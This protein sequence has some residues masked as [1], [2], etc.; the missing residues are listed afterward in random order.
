VRSFPFH[1]FLI[2]SATVTDGFFLP[3]SSLPLSSTLTARKGSSPS[4]LASTPSRAGSP[5]SSPFPVPFILLVVLLLLSIYFPILSSALTF[6][7]HSHSLRPVKVEGITD[8]DC[9]DILNAGHLTLRDKIPEV[10]QRVARRHEYP[11][12]DVSATPEEGVEG[13]EEGV[14]RL[15]VVEE[16]KTAQEHPEDEERRR[17]EGR[18]SVDWGENKGRGLVQER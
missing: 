12:G 4:L 1:S 5:G 16:R 3:F 6:K 7:Y 8:V 18:K 9:T 15:S 13:V 14:R 10:L 2:L 17:K 11:A